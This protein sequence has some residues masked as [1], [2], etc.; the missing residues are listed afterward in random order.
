MK[1]AT[2][3]GCLFFPAGKNI[4]ARG[5]RLTPADEFTYRIERKQLLDSGPCLSSPCFGVCVGKSY[6]L[7]VLEASDFWR[8]EP[9]TKDRTLS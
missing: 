1:S 4:L 8:G 9:V 2:F 6:P 3:F 5:G 7:H